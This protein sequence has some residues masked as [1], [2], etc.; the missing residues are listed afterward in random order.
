[1]NKKARKKIEW[2]EEPKWYLKERVIKPYLL[3]QKR[4]Y[5]K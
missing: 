3:E 1:M 2:K 5:L 4:E